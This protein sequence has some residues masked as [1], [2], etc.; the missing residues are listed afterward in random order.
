MTWN[1]GK[2][3]ES[4]IIHKTALSPRIPYVCYSD[5]DGVSWSKPQ[6][7]NEVGRDNS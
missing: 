3:S 7:M 5:D 1:D 6:S 4:E 2:D